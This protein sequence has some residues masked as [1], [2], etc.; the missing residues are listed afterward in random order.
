MSLAASSP[1]W[2]ERSAPSAP[3][4]STRISFP[5]QKGRNA[6]GFQLSEFVPD[7]LRRGGRASFPAL[8]HGRRKRYPR[9]RYS[10]HLVP[11]RICRNNAV[12]TLRNPDGRLRRLRSRATRCSATTTIPIPVAQIVFPGGDASLVGNFEYHIT[13]AGPVALAPFVD[14]GIDPIIRKSQLRINPGALSLINN[15]KFGCPILDIALNCLGTQSQTFGQYLNT[16]GSPTG[17]Q[18]CPPDWSCRS[19]CRW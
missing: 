16:V 11:W 10:F 8:L 2:A 6:L 4:C 14:I 18:E 9:L 15:A 5:M 17:P 12:V 19:F 1:G 13:I 7:R 3:S